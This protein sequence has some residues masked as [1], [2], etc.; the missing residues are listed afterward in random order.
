MRRLIIASLLVLSFACQQ[1]KNPSTEVMHSKASDLDTV[2]LALDWTPNVLHSGILLA[3]K[4]AWFQEEGIY[5]EWDTPEIDNYTKKPILRLLDGEVDF[6]I[7]PS[8][9]LFAFAMD[10]NGAIKA[11]AVATLLQNDR[12]AFVLKA[13]AQFKSPADIKT[14]TYLGYHTPL[15]HE[16]LNAMIRDAGAEPSY[17]IKEPGRLQVW[18]AFMQDSGQVAWVF[19]HW[20]AAM[21]T[22]Q[23][24]ELV[25]FIPNDYGVP[26]GYSSVLVAPSD[27]D[28]SDE[29]RCRRFLKVLA[30]AYTEVAQNP[31]STMQEIRA[32]N[33]HENWRDSAFVQAAIMDIYPHYLGESRWGQMKEV[34][35]QDYANWMQEQSL[36]EISQE[37]LKQ[38]YTNR[39]LIK[40]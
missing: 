11:Q 35:W 9:H 4:R 33:D 26:Y 3:E 39:F 36:V 31:F 40:K 25:S 38:L 14:A 18:D 5:L 29:D 27:L 17:A 28:S 8:E 32:F 12:S 30:R 16:I 1:N 20:E 37:Q 22:A 19:L 2:H 13:D 15:E 7:A 34:K 24:Q 6:A 23:G 21:A 10:D